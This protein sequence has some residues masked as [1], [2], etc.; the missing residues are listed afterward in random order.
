MIGVAP[1]LLVCR[2]DEM[3][4]GYYKGH[5]ILSKGGAFAT[6]LLHDV[7]ES[8]GAAHSVS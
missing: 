8:R 3:I 5:S 7:Q 6:L 2:L 4:S 1:P